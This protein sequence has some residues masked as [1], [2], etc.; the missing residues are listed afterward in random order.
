MWPDGKLSPAVIGQSA[1][2]IAARAAEAAGADRA[3]WRAI[4]ARQPRILIVD[5]DG[6]GREHPFS[7]EKLS[8][9]LTVYAAADFAAACAIV[10]RIYAYEGAGHSVGLQHDS[11]TSA[12]SSSA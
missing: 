8:P 4:A 11:A 6:V 10:E 7:G 9:V 12:P 2:A 5:E 1:A 3:A